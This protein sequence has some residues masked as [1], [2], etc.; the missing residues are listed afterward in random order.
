MNHSLYLSAVVVAAGLAACDKPTVVAVPSPSPSP[1]TV[2]VPAPGP[3]GPAGAT[4]AM[5]ATG[6]PG[7]TAVIVVPPAS[8]AGK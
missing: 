3:A 5:G 7:D 6:R 8:G 2:V 1:S 4:G